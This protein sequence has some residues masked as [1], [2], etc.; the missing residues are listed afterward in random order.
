[1]RTE[2]LH[3]LLDNDD[4]CNMFHEVAQS[5]VQA[6]IPEE[7]LAA[8]R[9]VEMTA[10][11][12]PNG[13]VRGIIF[14]D[15][16]RRLVA[17]TMAKQFMARFETATK[18]FQYALATRAGCES[19]AH[20]VQVACDRDPRA[21]V[22]SFD[23]V[24]AFDLISRRAMV[25]AVHRMPDGDTLLP[26]I[27]Q[28][29]GHPYL[30][31]WEDEEGVVHEI[32]EGEGGEQGDPLMPALFA[33][34]Q[35]QALEAIQGSLQPSEILMAF[36]D[37]VYV[38]TLPD[39]VATVE[40]SVE[41]QLW[42]HARIQVNQGKT[43]VWNRCG[44]RPPDCE[45]LFHKA[46]GTPNDVWRGDPGLPSHKQGVIILGTPLGRAEFVEG[47]LA[48]KIEEHGIL[49][50]RITKVTD[51]QS[52]WLLLLFCAASRANYVLRV[53]HPENSFQF[54]IQHDAGIRQCLE[55]LLH[56]PVTDA[57]WAMASLPFGSEG[58]SL[59]NAERL[60]TTAYWSTWADT[61]PM[62]RERHPR[63][64]DHILV[65]LSQGGGGFHLEA[66][67]ESRDCL[68]RADV[69]VPEW[70]DVNRGQ[71]P[72]S[73][74]DDEFPRFSRMG[75]QSFAATE[76]E[77]VFF[78]TT[79]WPRLD[80]THRALVQSQRGPMASIPF[81][82]PPVSTASRFDPQSF[83]VLLLR[84]LWCQFP[85]CSATCRSRGHHRGACAHAGVLGRRGLPLESCAARICRRQ[86]VGQHSC[87]RPRPPSRNESR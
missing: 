62:I 59:R 86:G 81:F 66:A 64:A 85:L 46:D 24:G 45:H 56:I 65:S 51:L 9:V 34:G 11:Q 14:G 4:D 74:Q 61:L 35:H 54:A 19:I 40:Q 27:L 26:F 25:S 67:H 55:D 68:L 69:A 42:D 83:R 49:L 78:D 70:G 30:H 1:M 23:G 73:H 58:L 75:W 5:F 7:I 79:V 82:T 28:F 29:C 48:E 6:S 15:V 76:I 80:P 77:E 72:G 3:P 37:D 53:V 52:A 12:K 21:T 32:Q 44:E 8:L 17:K 87:P 57:V 22:L 13:G 31:L 38:T 36:Q 71:R 63:V 39:R 10:L 50:D 2:H 16:I 47:Q 84:R 60:R 43:Q 33:L 18:P 41:I 20:A